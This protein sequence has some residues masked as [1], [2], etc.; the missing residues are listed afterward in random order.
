EKTADAAQRLLPSCVAI[1]WA[2][3]SNG[4]RNVDFAPLRG[5]KVVCVPDADQP[6]REAFCGRRNRAGKWVPGILEALS[7][8]GAMTRLAD[9]GAT[10]PDGWDLADAEAEGWNTPTA[11]DWLKSRVAEARHAA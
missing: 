7:A 9:P 3:G 1:T 6:G 2:G 5:R 4:Y 8:V 11:L 10:C